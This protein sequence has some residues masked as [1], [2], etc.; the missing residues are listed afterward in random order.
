MKVL[1]LVCCCTVFYLMSVASHFLSAH[2]TYK[3]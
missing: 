1:V 2:L 3:T